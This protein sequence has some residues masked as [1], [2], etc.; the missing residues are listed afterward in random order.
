M[1]EPLP[2]AATSE[3][4]LSFAEAA[5][6][7]LRP[8]VPYFIAG[9]LF[10]AFGVFDP[11]FMLNWSPGIALLVVVVWAIPALWRRGRRR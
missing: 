1:E 5:R 4:Q 3:E 11:K 8:L 9:A 10:V 6:R 7:N 2:A